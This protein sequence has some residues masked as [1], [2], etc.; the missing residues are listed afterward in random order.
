MINF[1][2]TP[3]TKDDRGAQMI[4]EKPIYRIGSVPKV[5]AVLAARQRSEINFDDPVTKYLQKLLESPKNEL[6][7][8]DWQ[9]VTVAAL[10][11]H[12]GGVGADSMF[13]CINGS[14]K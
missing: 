9:E 1:H 6:D 13:M 14:G 2:Y 3:P 7:Y 4:D 12:L 5:F 8:I 11:A 10:A